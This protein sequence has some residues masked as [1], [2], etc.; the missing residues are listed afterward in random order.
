MYLGARNISYLQPD[1]PDIMPDATM[2]IRTRSRLLHTVSLIALLAAGAAPAPVR[3]APFRSLAQGLPASARLPVAAAG[4]AGGAAAMQAAQLG[5]RNLSAAAQKFAS[6][7]QA[8]AKL[9]AQARQG[10]GGPADGWLVTGGLQPAAGYQ[11]PG[12]GV[13]QGAAAPSLSAGATNVTI[14]QTAP[15]AVL[16]WQSFNVGRH[17]TLTFDQSAGGAAASSWSVLNRIE[18]PDTSP[19]QIFGAIH[20]QGQVWVLNLNGVLFGAGAQVN[21]HSLV[22]GAFSITDAQYLSTGLY[23]PKPSAAFAAGLGSVTVTA[24]ASIVTDAPASPTDGGGSVILLGTSAENDGLISTPAGQTILGAGQTF[25]LR[26]GYTASSTAGGSVTGNT[27]STVLG[28]EVEVTHGHA[29]TNTGIVQAATGDVTL[30]GQ[31]V[32][33]AGV[34]GVTTAV[35][36]RGT[37]HLL[38]PQN[39]PDFF[40]H[41]RARQRHLDHARRQCG[42]GA[43]LGATGEI[44]RPDR[45]RHERR[46]P[47]ERPVAAA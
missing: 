11:V 21:L 37:I 3:A 6:M 9:G 45:L 13:F 1:S 24:G 32:T 40:G 26:Q 41:A 15:K 29:V 12:S 30:V 17:T 47:V 19:T 27:A 35:G 38:T 14:V 44:C 2:P 34:I 31:T 33:Q 7:A 36:Q 5:A 43:R 42:R 4:N 25:M 23:A 18:S 39:D 22:A 28:S 46:Q 16:N 20:A 10:A 8:L